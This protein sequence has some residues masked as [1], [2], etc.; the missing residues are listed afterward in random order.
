MSETSVGTATTSSPIPSGV[1]V[2]GALTSARCM[3]VMLVLVAGNAVVCLA[4]LRMGTETI[5]LADVA[6]VVHGILEAR[7]VEM[8]TIGTSGVILVHVRLPRVLLAFT[9]GGCLA[10]VG[11]TLQALLRNPLADP[12]VLGISSGA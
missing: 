5:P 10:A 7:S 6:R 9:V 8:D 11:V 12:Y 1:S 2:R 4:A 3:T